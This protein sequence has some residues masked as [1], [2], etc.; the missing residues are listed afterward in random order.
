MTDTATIWDVQN[1]RGDW[2]LVGRK[3]Q[4]GN[5][6]D[7]AVI[8]SL[9]TDRTAAPDDVIPDGSSNPRG[10]WGDT[11]PQHP[12]GSRL[13]LLDRSVQTQEVLARANDCCAEALQWLIDDGVAASID[14]NAFFPAREMLGVEITINRTDGTVVPMKFQW[15]WKQLN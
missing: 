4:D 10:W 15:S 6:L 2:V 7:T 12:I 5:D 8:I 3:L 1:G 11:D 13:W 14:V 9:F